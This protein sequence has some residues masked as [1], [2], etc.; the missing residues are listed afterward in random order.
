M[1]PFFKQ[2]KGMRLSFWFGGGMND[3][4]RWVLMG[5]KEGDCL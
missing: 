1:Q 4:E 2:I 5:S 3:W